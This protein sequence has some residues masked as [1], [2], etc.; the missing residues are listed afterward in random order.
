M[1]LKQKLR[2]KIGQTLFSAMAGV[3]RLFSGVSLKMFEPSFAG[4][5]YRH[6]NALRENVK[7][8][9]FGYGIHLCIGASLA[10][11]EAKV[12]FESLLQRFP[13][14][15]LVDDQPA[16]GVNPFFR[17]LDHLNI[18]SRAGV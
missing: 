13:D 6:F 18:E 14:V 12:T 7:Q 17:G 11:L 1:K 4:N 15:T 10:R 9:S 5:P 16:W 8:V 3:D 2:I